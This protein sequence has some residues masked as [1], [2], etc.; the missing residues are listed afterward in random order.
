MAYMLKDSLFIC[1]TLS[2]IIESGENELRYINII[3][4]YGSIL[5]FWI[6]EFTEK[7][8]RNINFIAWVKCGVK[9]TKGWLKVVLY[10]A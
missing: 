8:G 9:V 7:Y 10:V 2:N 4:W 1:K 3:V 6:P 5:P